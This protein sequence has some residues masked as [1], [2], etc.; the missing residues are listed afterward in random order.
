M[1]TGDRSEIQSSSLR[2]TTSTV[3]ATRVRQTEIGSAIA[4]VIHRDRRFVVD[5]LAAT[6]ARIAWFERG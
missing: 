6:W 4:C 3:V 2:L 5:R 1:L